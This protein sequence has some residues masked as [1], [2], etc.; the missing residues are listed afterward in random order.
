MAWGSPRRHARPAE[1][2]LAGLFSWRFYRVA[3]LV[4]TWHAVGAIAWLL[5]G[6]PIRPSSADGPGTASAVDL[7]GRS[8]HVHGL[9]RQAPVSFAGRLLAL[10]WMFAAILL[11]SV[12]TAG[13]AP[14]DRGALKAGHNRR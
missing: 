8:H 10:I 4:L 12:F 5:N 13:S 2:L 9:W 11:V 3:G 14:P 6:A 7:V 1:A